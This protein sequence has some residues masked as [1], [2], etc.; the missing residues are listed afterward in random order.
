MTSL[1]DTAIGKGNPVADKRYI[2]VQ[3]HRGFSS[4]YPE[5][6]IP[7]FQAAIDAG[8]DRLEM[9]LSLTRDG[10]VVLIHDSTVD[11]TTDGS[12]PVSL[13]RLDQLRRLDAG[14]WKSQEFAGA[15]IPTLREVIRLA[16]AS[17]TLNLEIKVVNVA[18]EEVRETI[19]TA[20]GVVDEEEAGERVVFSSFSIDALRAVRSVNPS[21]R[22]LLID[23]SDPAEVDGLEIAISEG[24]YGWT[25]RSRFAYEERIRRASE[26]GLVT[27]IGGVAPG[28]DLWRYVEWGIGG[29]SADN[30]AT[31]IRFLAEHGYRSRR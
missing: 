14:S 29:F 31:L 19:A 12:G 13:F 15:R 27:H 17:V 30:P 26:A 24:I 11:R 1:S 22:L 10:E 23:W 3:A 2:F 25:T 6:T 5:Q 28:T 7:A 4:D 8:A 21:R 20:L 16:D 9:D 18:A